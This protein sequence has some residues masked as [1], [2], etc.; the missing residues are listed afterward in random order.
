MNNKLQTIKQYSFERFSRA[1]NIY[2]DDTLSKEEKIILINNIK[3]ELE[4]KRPVFSSS[5][6]NT[7]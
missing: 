6:L 1:L 5:N 3:L 2:L 7:D 4:N